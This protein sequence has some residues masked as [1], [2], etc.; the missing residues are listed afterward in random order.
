MVKAISQGEKTLYQCEA[1]GLHYEDAGLAKQCEA[2][3]TAHNSCNTEITKQAI[4][5]QKLTNNQ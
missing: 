4:E 2:W 3:C 5:N 1:C